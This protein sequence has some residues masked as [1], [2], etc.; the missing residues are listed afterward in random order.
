[1]SDLSSLEWKDAA[2]G[3][4]LLE[5]LGTYRAKVK[6]AGSKA[7][8]VLVTHEGALQ[9]AGRGTWARETGVR[10]EGTARASPGA[11]ADLRDLLRLLGPETS[12]GVHAL[13]F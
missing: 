3:L 6:G 5:P 7:Q 2:S 4:S 8:F 10:F 11:E 12:R 13:R 9:V 1:M